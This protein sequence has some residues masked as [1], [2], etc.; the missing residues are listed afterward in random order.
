MIKSTL[1]IVSIGFLSAGDKKMLSLNTIGFLQGDDDDDLQDSG[2]L[3]TNRRRKS[4]K[5]GL[6][7]HSDDREVILMVQAFFKTKR[8]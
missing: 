3:I 6:N 4:R 5:E 2:S 7:L 1:S 8:K